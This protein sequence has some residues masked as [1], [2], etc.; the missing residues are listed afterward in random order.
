LTYTNHET[1]EII[2]KNL[3]RSPL[4]SGI[5]QGIGPR[6][7][8]SLE[9]KVV[10]FAE[11]ERH[12][13]FLEPE[14]YD[15]IEVYPNGISTSLPEEIQEAFVRTIRGLEEVKILRPGYAVE[16]DFVP[17]T[18]LR[19]SLETKRIEGLY[20][21]G[22]INGTSGYEEAAAQGLIAGINAALKLQGRPPIILDRS[23]AYI[24]V[25]IDDLVTL[26]TEE[27]YRM[28]TSRAEYRLLLRDD[29]ADVRLREKG[30]ALGL[31][32]EKEYR[33]FREKRAEIEGEIVRLRRIRVRDVVPEGAFP[34]EPITAD[35]T[36]AQFLQRPEVAYRQLAPYLPVSQIPIDDETRRR[37]EIEVKYEGYIHRQ[38]QMVERAKKLEHRRIPEEMDYE[39]LPGLSREVK[40]KL[41]KINPLTIG[42]ASRIS[43]VTPAAIS[44][45]LIALAKYER[46]EGGYTPRVAS[47]G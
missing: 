7:C 25:M 31:V 18:Q 4:Y 1:H 40:E 41:K 20:L 29:N 22:Q 30:F 11:R 13:V 39:G 14:G 35:L 12:Q 26:G 2:K 21:A 37:V 34:S 3:D 5:I 33:D 19:P 24:G 10:R 36:V 23:E 15:A 16:Y 38:M 47:V 9:D 43:G 42:Q 45:L 32:S 44:I 27:P 46:G 17:P 8:P 28:F 6:Y